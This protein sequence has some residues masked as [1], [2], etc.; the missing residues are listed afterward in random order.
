MQVGSIIEGGRRNYCIFILDGVV[1]ALV[2]TSF[3]M[4]LMVVPFIAVMCF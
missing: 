1:M 4:D 3:L 2:M